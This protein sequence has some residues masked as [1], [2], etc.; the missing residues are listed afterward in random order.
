MRKILYLF[1]ILTILLTGCLGDDSKNQYADW[2]KQNDNYIVA[3]ESEVAAGKSEYTRLSADW[4]PQ[5]SVFVKWHNDRSETSKN[6]SPLSNS[7]VNIT[8][9]ME[10]IDGTALGDSYS[11]TTWGDS[12]Y[13]SKP[14][15]NIAGMWIAMLNMHVGDSVTMII[16]YLSGYGARAMSN[17]KPYSNLIYHVKMKEVVKY[18][19]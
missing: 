19:Y 10:D 18:E 1:P 5:N 8:Y 11:T 4:A 9:A 17:I 13:Q 12:I 7:T 14:N 2:K 3:L 15:Q 6:L 16:P